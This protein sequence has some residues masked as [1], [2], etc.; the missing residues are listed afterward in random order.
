MLY[1]M[2]KTERFSHK[3]GCAMQFIKCL[4]QTGLQCYSKNFNYILLL[5]SAI[6]MCSLVMS[7]SSCDFL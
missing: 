1:V 7:L 6:T 5:K 4:K 3:S 2:Y